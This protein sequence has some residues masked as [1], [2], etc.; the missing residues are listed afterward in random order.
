MLPGVTL[1]VTSPE[2]LG[3]FT[4]VTDAQGVYRVTNLPPAT[5]DVR[6]ELAGS[7]VVVRCTS[8]GAWQID[9]RPSRYVAALL[10]DHVSIDRSSD[11]TSVVLRKTVSRGLRNPNGA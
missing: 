7:D 3:Q 9:A 11:T 1:T 10:V 4:A 8:S 2:A 6:A 5:Y